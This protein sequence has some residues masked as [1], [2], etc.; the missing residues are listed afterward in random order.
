MNK[1]KGASDVN[2]PTS[3]LDEI[4]GVEIES[5]QKVSNEINANEATIDEFRDIMNIRKKYMNMLGGTQSSI[6]NNRFQASGGSTKKDSTGRFDK[7]DGSAGSRK[8]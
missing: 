4:E 6:D 3:W 1:Y 5:K 7:F 8:K 2:L